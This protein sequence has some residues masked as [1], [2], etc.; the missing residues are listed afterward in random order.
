MAAMEVA[1]KVASALEEDLTLPNSVQV[2]VLRRQIKP[3]RVT[4][5]RQGT[6]V[7]TSLKTPNCPPSRGR[8]AIRT[9]GRRQTDT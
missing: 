2:T 1:P 6:T 4:W 8:V 5:I 3:K 9:R 7:I